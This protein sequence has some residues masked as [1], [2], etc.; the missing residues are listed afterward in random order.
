MNDEIIIDGVNVAECVYFR[1]KYTRIGDDVDNDIFFENHC[2]LSEF[3]I[4]ICDCNKIYCYFK[5]F[6]RLKK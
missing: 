2:M 1:D 6:Q 5:Q 3:P 4:N